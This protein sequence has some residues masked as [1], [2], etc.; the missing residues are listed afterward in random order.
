[1]VRGRVQFYNRKMGKWV[2]VDTE[3]GGF[4]RASRNKH[5]NIREV[6]LTSISGSFK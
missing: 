3:R 6:Y 4:L 1:M 2:V 5:K